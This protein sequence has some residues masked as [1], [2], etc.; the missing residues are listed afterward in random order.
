MTAA[1]HAPSG[2]D[3]FSCSTET[4]TSSRRQSETFVAALLVQAL[5]V[6]VVALLPHSFLSF[7]GNVINN[8]PGD[9]RMSRVVH[10]LG[11][12]GGG[13]G[14]FE[15]LPASHGTLPTA[16][17]N[18]IV[19]PTVILPKEMPKISAPDTVVLAPE[20]K[21]VAGDQIGDPNSQFTKLLSNGPGGP[22]GIG[23]G[24]CGWRWRFDRAWSRSRPRRALFSRD[25]RC[26]GPAR[27][28]QPG[29]EFFRGSA[30][31]ENS[32]RGYVVAGGEQRRAYARH[33]REAQ[34]G[35]GT[36]REVG[37]SC[38]PMAIPASDVR[39]AARRRAD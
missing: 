6:A 26:Y 5:L 35:H 37:R 4:E 14:S 20:L 8:L 3:L 2:P 17:L 15:K 18:Q 11:N 23:R 29:T 9:S 32:R 34:S 10:F 30:Q 16:S 1:V 19:P 27:H 21:I 24:C 39:R 22:G 25:A 38:Q 33:Q 36:R 13:G 7:P 12:S 28:L 31:I